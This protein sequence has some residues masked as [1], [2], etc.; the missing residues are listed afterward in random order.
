MISFR[1]LF[2]GLGWILQPKDDLLARLVHSSTDFTTLRPTR[3]YLR[4]LVRRSSP[5]QEMD[6]TRLPDL[7][8]A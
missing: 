8:A 1:L 3:D 7:D 4:S 5:S 6:D 2:V